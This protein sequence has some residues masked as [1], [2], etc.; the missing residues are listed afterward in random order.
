MAL[1]S[2]LIGSVF[3]L[4]A[5]AWFSFIALY[6]PPTNSDIAFEFILG[7]FPAVL[8][9]LLTV[10]STIFRS[11]YVIT[12]KPEQTSKDKVILIIG[13]LITFSYC[14]AI[15]KLSFT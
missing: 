9:L 4:V 1:F 5:V 12:R 13:L 3:F 11:F 10:P 8:G 15:L 6:T 14:G 2:I 7:V